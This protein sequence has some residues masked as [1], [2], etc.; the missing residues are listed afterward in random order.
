MAS[1]IP[2]PDTRLPR[3]AVRGEVIILMPRMKQTIAT[4]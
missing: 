2:T 1:S 4:R 3:W